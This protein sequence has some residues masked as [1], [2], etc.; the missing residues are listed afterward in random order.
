MSAN[1]MI[2]KKIS[3]EKNW[4]KTELKNVTI[5]IPFTPI[6]W[7]NLQPEWVFKVNKKFQ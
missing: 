7:P 2:F 3:A 5:R 4:R 1:V 6:I